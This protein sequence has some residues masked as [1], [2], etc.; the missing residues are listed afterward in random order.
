MS[1]TLFAHPFSSYSQ[2]VLTALYENDIPFDL[3]LLAHD[4]PQ[5]AAEHAALW[6]LKRMPVLVDDDRTIVE[7]TV[8]IE[9]LGLYHPGPARL[10]PDDP[11][12]ALG[13]RMMDRFFDNYVM[14]PVQAIVSDALRPEESRDAYGAAK[15]RI[16]LDPAYAWLDGCVN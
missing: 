7:S 12:T 4:D 15:A 8:I 5:T 11:H 10:V 16:Q 3:R 2:K 1:L 13:V 14:T 9:Y 6:P